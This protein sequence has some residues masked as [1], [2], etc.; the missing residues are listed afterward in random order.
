[1]SHA[2]CILRNS[3]WFYGVHTAT[4]TYRKRVLCLQAYLP[5]TNC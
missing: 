3:E 1:M 5:L 4:P 2:H